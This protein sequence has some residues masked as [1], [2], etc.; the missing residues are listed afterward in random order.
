MIE[1]GKNPKHKLSDSKLF[2]DIALDW[3]QTQDYLSDR[4][5]KTTTQRLNR[6]IDEF[7][8]IPISEIDSIQMLTFLQKI[9]NR[10]ILKPL[11]ESSQSY[12]E[13]MNT[14]TFLI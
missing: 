7:G 8:H 4:T 2:K 5:T 9:E 6:C 14:Q 10:G 13:C 1:N 3:L 12:R 11:K